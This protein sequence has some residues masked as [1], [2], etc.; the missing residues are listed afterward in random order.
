[1]KQFQSTL[2]WSH[3]YSSYEQSFFE[4]VVG[5]LEAT[6]L[7]CRPWCDLWIQFVFIFISK[8]LCI[9]LWFASPYAYF[10]PMCST[11]QVLDFVCPGTDR[12]RGLAQTLLNVPYGEGDGEKLDV[13]IPKG[14]PLGT[15]MT[16]TLMF[17]FEDPDSYR[18]CTRMTFLL[19]QTFISSFTYM[20]ATGSF[21]GTSL[22]CLY[23]MILNSSAYFDMQ[24]HCVFFKQRG[25]RFYGRSTCR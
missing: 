3:K 18:V 24:V 8:H 15:A 10:H 12:A 6:V 16:L 19:F 1:M 22:G 17:T 11:L 5:L 9:I 13:Y 14:S 23:N 21:S 25:V 7:N 20:E 2:K 4:C